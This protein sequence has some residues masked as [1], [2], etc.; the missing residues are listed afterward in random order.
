MRLTNCYLG[1]SFLALAA[2]MTVGCGDSNGPVAPTT[3]AI[4]ITVSTTSA[5]IDIDP[6][7]Y[8]LTIDGGPVHFVGVNSTWTV[9]ALPIGSH[10]VR[11]DGL[12]QN[13]GVNGANPLSVYVTTDKPPS[14]ASFSVA[15]LTLKTEP[16]PWDY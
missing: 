6:D 11:L 13:C 2:I 7:G 1:A 10:L 15:C 14:P 3:G 5:I 8:Y 9:A 12:A 4:R 16:G